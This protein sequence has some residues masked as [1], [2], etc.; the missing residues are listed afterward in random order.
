LAL[1]GRSYGALEALVFPFGGLYSTLSK[2]LKRSFYFRVNFDTVSCCTRIFKKKEY[3]ATL[4][5][6]E[7][8]RQKAFFRERLQE[9]RNRDTRNNNNPMALVRER[10]IPTERLPLVGEVNANFCG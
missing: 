8:L 6:A 4:E 9:R 2:K 10:T 3:T 1:N 5:L 7:H